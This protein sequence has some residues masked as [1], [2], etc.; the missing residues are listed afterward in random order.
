MEAARWAPPALSFEG[1]LPAWMAA[2]R[3]QQDTAVLVQRQS[4]TL[5]A[6]Q[7]PP[8]AA[9]SALYVQKGEDNALAQVGI[10]VPPSAMEAA[11]WAPFSLCF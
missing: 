5:L 2:A 4:D 8:S 6:S 9:D 3:A 10:Q 11:R 1:P 7:R